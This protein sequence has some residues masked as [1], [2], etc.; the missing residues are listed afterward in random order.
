MFQILPLFVIGL[1]LLV[2][3]VASLWVW[4]ETRLTKLPDTLEECE[5]MAQGSNTWLNCGA[6]QTLK[7]PTGTAEEEEPLE[8]EELKRDE[9]QIIT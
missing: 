5:Q 4:P 8:Q 6:E 3:A 7:T 2:S 9:R 1:F